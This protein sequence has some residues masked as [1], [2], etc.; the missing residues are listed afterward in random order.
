MAGTVIGL[1]LASAALHL[2]WNLVVR[3]YPGSVKFVWCLTLCGGLAAG[4]ATVAFH[5]PVHFFSVWPWLI[6][7]IIAH[8]VYF[9]GLARSYGGGDLGEV[10]PATRGGGII[11]TTVSAWILW[12]QHLHWITLGG[13]GI[14]AV[15]VTRPAWHA[16][17]RRQTLGW[18]LLVALSITAYSTIDNHGVRL[19][20]PVAYIACQFLGT[21]LILTPLALRDRTP[22]RLGP[23]ATSGLMSVA[24]YLLI[25]FAYQH[26]A[27][28]P[29]LALRQVGMVVAPLVGW[30]VLKEPMH[31]N[32]L[33]VSLGIAVGSGLVMFK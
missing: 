18:T 19:L 26:G 5:I 9:V 6:G 22:L 29:I 4:L 28:A 20:S 8:G 10:Y 16:R 14:I 32:A 24:S 2:T 23:S 3:R 13:I 7:T 31:H 33:W 12:G 11:G 17:W 30:W 25:L 27:A 15:L 1:V 21:A